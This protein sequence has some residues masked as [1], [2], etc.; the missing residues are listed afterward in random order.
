[1][2]QCVTVQHGA[3]RIAIAGM[4]EVGDRSPLYAGIAS[5]DYRIA[6]NHTPN[7]ADE[8][9]AHGVNLYCCGHTHGGQVRIPFWG[10]IITNAECGKRYEAGFYQR[11]NTS[12]HTSR[13][14]GLEPPPAVQVRF[15]CRPEITLI[16]VE[17]RT[18]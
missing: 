3:R 1:M 13:G 8:A 17:P 18:E 16:T 5:A 10:A 6:I 11:G 12:I 2:N 9:V 4:Q 14:L 7:L 15:L